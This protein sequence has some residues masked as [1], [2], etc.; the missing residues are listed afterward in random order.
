MALAKRK[1]DL[2]EKLRVYWDRDTKNDTGY[3]TKHHPPICHRQMRPFNIN[4][5]NLVRKILQTIRLCEGLLN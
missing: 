1:S 5:S 4:T 3:F 2:V